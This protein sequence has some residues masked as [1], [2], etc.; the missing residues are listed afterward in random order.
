MKIVKTL[1]FVLLLAGFQQVNGQTILT[2]WENLGNF[3]EVL[4]KTNYVANEGLFDKLNQITPIL[5]D[6]SQK[7]DMN[8]IP[9]K[10]RTEKVK[11]TIAKLRSQTKNLD[12]LAANKSSKEDLQNELNAV[13]LTYKELIALC[14][15]D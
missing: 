3:S 5:A 8:N 10:L 6:F 7:L 14:N 11:E 2:K 1:L 12:N 13:N 4:T 9:E 15:L